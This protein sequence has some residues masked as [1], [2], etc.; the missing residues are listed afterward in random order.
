MRV[1]THRLNSVL[2]NLD[3][4]LEIPVVK[5]LAQ[6]VDIG[7]D[8]WLLLE[9]V[10]F[11]EL[12]AVGDAGLVVLLDDFGAFFDDMRDVL[13]DEVEIGKGFSELHAAVADVASNLYE[14]S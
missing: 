2:E 7:A 1:L 8:D 10:V 6:E 12:D 13:D 5:D 4:V 14:V 3:R 11:L 9:E